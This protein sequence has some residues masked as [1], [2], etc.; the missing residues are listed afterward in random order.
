MAEAEETEAETDSTQRPVYFTDSGREVYGG[1]GISPDVS[2]ELDTLQTLSREALRRGLYFKYAVKYVAKNPDQGEVLEV[3]A[4]VWQN[5][6]EFLRSEEVE[7][8]AAEM[9]EQREFLE[10][11]I[12]RE[13]ARRVGGDAAAFRAVTPGDRT[14]QKALE[15]LRKANGPQDLIQLS[16]IQ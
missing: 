4:E 14:L 11:G 15:L 1:G 2:V 10:L 7:F 3:D 5:F 13:I 6:A 12:K 8:T 9:E 16:S